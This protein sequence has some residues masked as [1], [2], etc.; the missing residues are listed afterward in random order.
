MKIEAINKSNLYNIN[1]VD[2]TFVVDSK[3]IISLS[4]NKFSFITEP[5]TP[6][7]KRYGH[8]N[9][10]Y[11]QY[12]NNKS[13]TVFFA[14][15]NEI[16]AGQ[17]ILFTKWNDYACIDDIRIAKD[18]RRKGIGKA[19]MQKA[20]EW[21]KENNFFGMEVETQDVNV[22]ACLFYE[23]CGFTLGA[24]DMFRYKSSPIEKNE[25]ALSWYLLF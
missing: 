7:E 12:I 5:V 20:I 21:S 23:K 15:E 10:D 3:L 22:K 24:V 13:K 2:S 8:E 11:S 9:F 25:I 1:Q 17:I 19:L 4:D 16:L 18:Y 6:Y 14:F